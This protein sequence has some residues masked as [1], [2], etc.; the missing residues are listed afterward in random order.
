MTP[1]SDQILRCKNSSTPEDLGY[2][3]LI[4]DNYYQI[5]GPHYVANKQLYIVSTLDKL[6]VLSLVEEDIEKYFYTLAEER[7]VKL[8]NLGI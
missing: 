3:E 6:G 7:E 8:I 1:Y 4:F 5:T 2:R